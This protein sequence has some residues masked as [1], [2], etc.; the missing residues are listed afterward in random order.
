MSK[1]HDESRDLRSVG[2]IG[3]VNPVEKSI[4]ISKGTLI[5]IHMW[6]KLDYLT[7]YCGYHIVW[8]GTVVAAPSTKK[9]TE[10]QPSAR[11]LKKGN[12]E[13]A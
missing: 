2:R 12:I 8:N 9:N 7:N 10:E 6:G 5:G 3:R 13:R 11:A 1:K 4:N